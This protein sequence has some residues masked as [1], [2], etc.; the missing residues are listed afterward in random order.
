LMGSLILKIHL[1]KNRSTM[2]FKIGSRLYKPL[3]KEALCPDA[4]P[5]SGLAESVST[6]VRH[7]G[8]RATRPQP[9]YLK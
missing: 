1:Q 2:I 5:A 3:T 9:H 6:A 7:R 4:A 8:S